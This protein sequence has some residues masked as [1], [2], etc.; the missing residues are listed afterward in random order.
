MPRIKRGCPK[1]TYLDFQSRVIEDLFRSVSTELRECHPLSQ[2]RDTRNS[3]KEKLT[4]NLKIFLENNSF[5]GKFRFN[6]VS[7]PSA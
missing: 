5:E 7:K 2:A 4:L 1:S 3:R 6:F